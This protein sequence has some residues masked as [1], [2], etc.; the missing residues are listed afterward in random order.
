M[1]DKRQPTQ[2]SVPTPRPEQPVTLPG[3]TR[4]QDSP[5]RRLAPDTPPPPPPAPPRKEGK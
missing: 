1:S 2:P 4:T 5:G 3:R